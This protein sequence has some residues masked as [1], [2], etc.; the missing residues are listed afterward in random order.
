MSDGLNTIL[1][2]A[3][4]AS[5]SDRAEFVEQLSSIIAERIGSSSQQ[6]ALIE[7]RIEQMSANLDRQ[8]LLDQLMSSIIG[9]GAEKQTPQQDIVR[10]EAKIDRLSEAIEE[11]N[12]KLGI[13]N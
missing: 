3:I 5:Q 12:K 10:L 13:G 9:L 1:R 8:Q 6:A 4:V 2:S 11:L 7:S